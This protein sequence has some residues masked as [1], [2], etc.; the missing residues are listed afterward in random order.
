MIASASRTRLLLVTLVV[1]LFVA[2]CQG[3]SIDDANAP[4]ILGAFASGNSQLDRDNPI[5]LPSP[6]YQRRAHALWEN[7]DWDGLTRAVIENGYDIDLNWF[8]LGEAARGRGLTQ[9]ARAY[10]TKAYADTLASDETKRC[11][12]FG[13]MCS[14]FA[15][16]ADISTALEALDTRR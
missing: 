4:T 7:K 6:W 16:P 8:Y 14:G 5:A 13:D 11:A 2:A 9:A 1:S 3:P 10:Y 15:F 12:E